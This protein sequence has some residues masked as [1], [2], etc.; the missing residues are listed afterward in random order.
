MSAVQIHETK[1]AGHSGVQEDDQYVEGG[2][3]S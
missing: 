3:S 1:G 2:K